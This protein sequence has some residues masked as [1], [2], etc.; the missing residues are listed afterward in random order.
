VAPR[1]AV[2]A[3]LPEKRDPHK[4][5]GTSERREVLKLKTEINASIFPGALSSLDDP[6][7]PA[8]NLAVVLRTLRRQP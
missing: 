5:L 4:L 3:A 1:K 8:F 6:D 7:V 2:G